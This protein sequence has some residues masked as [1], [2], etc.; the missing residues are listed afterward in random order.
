MPFTN[1]SIVEI[2]VAGKSN[3]GQEIVNVF[4]YRDLLAEPGT[5]D[6]ISLQNLLTSF[7][8]SWRSRFLPLL[9]QD[10]AVVTYRG[11]ALVGMITNP[12]P[13]PATRF[14]VGEQFD[15][16]ALTT[17]RGAIVGEVMP[18]FNAFAIQ[19]LSD[20]AGRNFRGGFRLGTISE[21]DV[22]GNT[23]PGIT[24]TPLQ[25]AA[26]NFVL[27]RLD[28]AFEGPFWALCVFSRKLALSAPPPF[29]DLRALTAGVTGARASS[30]VSSQVSRKQS[31][32]RVT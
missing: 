21:V 3:T 23:I 13:P 8:L 18:T 14:D 5:Y 24:L 10:Y 12:T 20:R 1:T 15:L 16:V 28:A 27:D 31:L 19:K 9:N 30:F 6:N 11:R 7:A 29:T 4:H 32:T 22:S 26:N 2:V 25:A 17:D